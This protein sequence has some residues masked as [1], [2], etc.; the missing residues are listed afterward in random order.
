MLRLLQ[1]SHRI[2]LLPCVFVE[3][4]FASYSSRRLVWR[5]ISRLGYN[6]LFW[7]NDKCLRNSCKSF[8]I[9]NFFIFYSTWLINYFRLFVVFKAACKLRRQLRNRRSSSSSICS[10]SRV[11]SVHKRYQW[12]GFGVTSIGWLKHVWRWVWL[13]ISCAQF[14]STR[15]VHSQLGWLYF[16]IFYF[17]FRLK[18]SLVAFFLIFSYSFFFSASVRNSIVTTTIAIIIRSQIAVLV[19]RPQISTAKRRD[20]QMA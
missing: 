16:V 6:R 10:I 14:E 5:E 15:F 9:L 13:P 2:D 20:F 1:T 7:H 18:S 19:M 3:R 11:E 4:L 17:Y 12:F 8:W